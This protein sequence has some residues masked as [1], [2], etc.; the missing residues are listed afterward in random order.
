MSEG[1]ITISALL[2][3]YNHAAVL[4]TAIEAMAGQTRPPDEFLILDDASTDHSVEIMESYAAKYPFIR[5]LRNA[6]NQ[7]VLKGLNR[8]LEEARGDFVYAGA[9]DDFV[10]PGFLE[11]VG[12]LA[13][14]YPHCGA[15][16]GKMRNVDLQGN[17]V[18]GYEIPAWE[19]PIYASPERVLEEYYF[20]VHCTHSISTATIF[21]REDAIEFGFEVE[22]GGWT[23]LFLIRSISLKRGICYYPEILASY[24]QDDNSFGTKEA[25]DP[26]KQNRIS[27]VAKELMASLKYRQYYTPEYAE[28]WV[29]GFRREMHSTCVCGFKEKLDEKL[30]ND[31]LRFR[32]SKWRS[33]FSYYWNALLYA[34]KAH[35][36]FKRLDKLLGEDYSLH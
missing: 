33:R 4:P 22:M 25:K 17:I 15:S 26:V 21:R 35:F 3:N 31:Q 36:F 27:Q 34:P 6:T 18:G 5:I 30:M 16:M 12:G 11:A 8:L 7:G 9:S 14:R 1:K 10:F 20:N 19:E 2:P 23:D 13:D 29:K 28:W 32:H 24:T